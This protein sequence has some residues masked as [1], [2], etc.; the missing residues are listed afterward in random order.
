MKAWL[1]PAQVFLTHP[2]W[3]KC[4]LPQLL[5]NKRKVYG[6]TSRNNRDR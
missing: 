5:N 3:R 4:S 2:N 6:I 1:Q